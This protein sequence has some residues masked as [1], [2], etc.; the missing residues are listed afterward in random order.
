MPAT[1]K[2]KACTT[3]TGRPEPVAP[4]GPCYAPAV[5]IVKVDGC[6]HFA[7]GFVFSSHSPLVTAFAICDCR[8]RPCRISAKGF[9]LFSSLIT[10]HS[11]LFTAFGISTCSLPGN[12]KRPRRNGARSQRPPHLLWRGVIS[13]C[14]IACRFQA[15]YWSLAEASAPTWRRQKG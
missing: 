7:L 10:H 12:E 6:P 1:R 11:S 14:I 5:L 8:T 4:P 2:R 15:F 3:E 13:N 9:C